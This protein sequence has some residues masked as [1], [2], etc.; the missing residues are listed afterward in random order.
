M[1]RSVLRPYEEAAKGA[2]GGGEKTRTLEKRKGAAPKG[3]IA[4]A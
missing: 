4:T 1:G 3:C 2:V